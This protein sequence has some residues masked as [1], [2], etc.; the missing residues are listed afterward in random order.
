MGEGRGRGGGEMG[1]GAVGRK[2]GADTKEGILAGERE[3]GYKLAQRTREKR[4]TC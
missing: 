3:M 4:Q 2:K 1:G